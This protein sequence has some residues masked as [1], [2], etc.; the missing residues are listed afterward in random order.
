MISIGIYG[1]GSIGK[2][3]AKQAFARGYYITGAVDIKEEL[4]EKN[5]GELIGQPEIEAPVT[6]D[7]TILIDSDIVIHTTTSF[8][9]E[10]YHQLETLARMGLNIISTTETLSYPWYRYPVI[11]RKLDKIA[12]EYNVSIL[13]TGINPGFLL[14]SLPII[15]T[16]PLASFKKITAVRSIDALKRRDTF[17]KKVGLGMD[18]GDY[19]EKKRKNELTGHV[20]YAESL[21]IIMDVLGVSPTEIR[22]WED[23]VIAKEYQV[24][25]EREFKKGTVLGVKGGA[26]ALLNDYKVARIEFH[27]YAGAPEYEEITIE[28]EEKTVTWKSNGV[29]GDK[30]TVAMVLSL[31]DTV[32]EA[33][34]GLLTMADIIPFKPF[35]KI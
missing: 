9:E 8:L 34:P 16:A 12:H 19:I 7:P 27:A 22:E 6:D 29:Q 31:I 33:K 11:A 23:P 15:L 35:L 10:V 28:T 17:Q 25:G 2:E 4:M 14:D 18:P 30:G 1:F 32:M 5:V 24:I 26:E 3:V 21:M 20:G 13:G